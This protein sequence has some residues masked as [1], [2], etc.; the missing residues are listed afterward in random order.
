MLFLLSQCLSHELSIHLNAQVLCCILF[1]GFGSWMLPA[2]SYRESKHLHLPS[3][4]C[5]PSQ[6]C[7]S[8]ESHLALTCCLPACEPL[9][10]SLHALN[11][12]H[13]SETFLVSF[14]RDDLPDTM[15][16]RAITT[17]S[18]FYICT[19][20]IFLPHISALVPF[21]HVFRQD[22]KTG[23]NY[24]SLQSCRTLGNGKPTSLSQRHNIIIL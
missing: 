24:T 9:N 7:I 5:R 15:P 3:L 19:S 1:H 10:C 17:Q 21:L 11:H 16:H 14:E 2:L 23:R 8:C 13:L 22:F 6:L 18:I 4:V 20:F 12:E